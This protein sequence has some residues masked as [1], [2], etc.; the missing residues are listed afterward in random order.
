PR[1][2]DAGPPTDGGL[3]IQGEHPQ[4]T[5]DADDGG[6][7]DDGGRGEDG[8]VPPA[9]GADAADHPH[10]HRADVVDVTAGEEVAHEPVDGEGDPDADE[11]EPVAGHAAAPG[12]EVDERGRGSRPEQ[13][14][15]PDE[16]PGQAQD[17]DGERRRSA[18]S[19]ADTEDVGAGERVAE[20]RLEDPTGH[21]QR[22]ADEDGQR[23]A[24][25]PDAADGEGVLAAA[26]AEQP[27]EVVRRLGGVTTPGEGDGDHRGAPPAPAAL[28]TDG[29][30]GRG[31]GGEQRGRHSPA[32]LVRRTMA[33]RTGAPTNATTSPT[34]S[35]P[36][37]ATS[38]P[39]TSAVRRRAGPTTTAKGST[40]R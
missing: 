9:R 20:H 40:H 32:V 3:G 19:A 18:R 16:E 26:A 36:G 22:D 33:M 14:R 29:L 31:R 17:D 11:D 12:E 34:S 24:G 13:G 38:R 30:T 35:S 21:A 37:R 23:H 4:P 1:A 15:E 39:T 6:R 5:G 25:Q 27:G 8:D 10:E 7:Q 2:R 28:G